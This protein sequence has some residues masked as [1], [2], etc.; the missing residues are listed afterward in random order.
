MPLSGLV[1]FST[2]VVR[3]LLRQFAGEL[4]GWPIRQRRHFVLFCRAS[5]GR[6][7]NATGFSL[8]AYRTRATLRVQFF[9]TDRTAPD[10][11][12]SDDPIRS[13]ATQLHLGMFVFPGF[14]Q[15]TI[16]LLGVESRSNADTSGS[17]SAFSPVYRLRG[18]ELS[19]TVERV[20]HFR[21]SNILDEE[22]RTELRNR[23]Q[24]ALHRGD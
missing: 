4:R 20:R 1:S 8:T 24:I 16:P 11:G 15:S 7:S 14:S 10:L 3:M 21:A 17:S 22:V 5:A 13:Y 6:R 9:R 18:S 12:A 2:G 23:D 19:G